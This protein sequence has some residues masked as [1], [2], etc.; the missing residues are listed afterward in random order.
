MNS[1]GEGDTRRITQG[2]TRRF[3]ILVLAG[4][5]LF[6]TGLQVAHVKRFQKLSPIDELQ[7]LDY[8]L[9]A[10][11]LDFPGSG[12]HV[13]RES[14]VVETCS[15]I[16]SPFDD[17]VPSCVTDS[18]APVDVTVL[19]EG[20]FNTAY[21]HPPG[22]YFIDGS[23]TRAA[24][25]LVGENLGLLT[26]GRLAGLFWVWAAVALL[27]LAFKEFEASESIAAIGIVLV[28]TAPTFLSAVSTINPDGSAVAVG[29]AA[30]WAA[31]RWERTKR[32]AWML[33]VVGAIAVM[34]KFSNLAGVAIALIFILVPAIR[35]TFRRV[36]LTGLRSLGSDSDDR[37]R[38]LLVGISGLLVAVASIALRIGQAIVQVIP[39]NE[40][41]MAA[42]TIVEHLPA[43]QIAASW[44]VG[45]S[46]LQAAW[47]ASFLQTA[48]VRT[49]IPI[50][51]FAVIA[52]AVV[53]GA[54]AAVGSRARRLAWCTLG[55]GVAF[56]PAFAMFLYFV[57][58]VTIS[59]PPRYGLSM[60]PALVVAAIP[61]LRIRL[62]F[63][64]GS[65]LASV[66]AIAAVAAMIHPVV[67]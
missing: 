53:G 55:V 26:V 19:Q 29:A 37:Q 4:L 67:I 20:G 6:A 12:D 36:R 22:Y 17:Y 46:P 61:L 66:A 2:R 3:R 10:P 62:G 59:I 49:L 14:A 8:L 42:P 16:E 43:I 25:A 18:A 52:G 56:G 65:L 38:I 32:G 31:A 1:D 23:I 60:V 51:D 44:R 33:V 48:L 57:Q 30:L 13:L 15:R 64:I 45:L 41:P 50:V 58:G 40:L 35:P 39:P 54:I 28:V 27:W 7:H 34:T 47:F 63:W 9:R 21:I 5:L 11:T 24:K